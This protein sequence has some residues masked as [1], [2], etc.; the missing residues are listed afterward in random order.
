MDKRKNRNFKTN[1]QSRKS[2]FE[3]EALQTEKV[4][5]VF[6]DYSQPGDALV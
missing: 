5:R 3:S 2:M 6:Y 1:L 4:I